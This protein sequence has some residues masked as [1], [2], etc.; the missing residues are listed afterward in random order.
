MIDRPAKDPKRLAME[1][2]R[3]W[4]R[5]KLKKNVVSPLKSIIFEKVIIYE[6]AASSWYRWYLS[7]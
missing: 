7:C 5:S 3:S 2:H 1:I 6:I 4:K